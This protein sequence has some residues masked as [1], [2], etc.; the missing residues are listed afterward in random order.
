M[1]FPRI[2]AIVGAAVASAMIAS[3]SAAG[4]G[5]YRHHHHDRDYYDDYDTGEVVDAPYTHVETGDRVVVDAP[6][7]H[8]YSGRHG[9]HIVAP[10]VDLWVPRADD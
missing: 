6:F 5:E 2:P 8:V 10:F 9:Q 1:A 7:A 4:A 3:M